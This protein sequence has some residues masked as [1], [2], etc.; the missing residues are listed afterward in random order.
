MTLQ[1]RLNKKK[2]AVNV[3]PDNDPDLCRLQELW[4]QVYG[5]ERHFEPIYQKFRTNPEA[6][7]D[8]YIRQYHLGQ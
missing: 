7:L 3:R 5:D 4:V 2:G 6:R 1:Q 8:D